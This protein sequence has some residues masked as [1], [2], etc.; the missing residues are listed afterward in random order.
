MTFSIPALAAG[1]AS[2][3]HR[4]AAQPGTPRWMRVALSGCGAGLAVALTECDELAPGDALRVCQALLEILPEGPVRRAVSRLRALLAMTESAWDV[5]PEG[6]DFTPFYSGGMRAYANALE[7]LFDA[8]AI[9]VAD[10]VD[11]P[12]PATIPESWREHGW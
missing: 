8:D 7:R 4:H 2:M 12:E 10:A 11:H 6:G 1:V 3:V 9:D 5:T